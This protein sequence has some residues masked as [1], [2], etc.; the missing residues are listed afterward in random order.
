MK[1]HDDL[2]LGQ[3]LSYF[4]LNQHVVEINHMNYFIYLQSIQIV[5]L[6]SMVQV[7]TSLAVPNV[8][9]IVLKPAPDDELGN[10]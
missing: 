10:F 9:L 6:P 2:S 5:S 3:F 1:D 8:S 7:Q 4:F